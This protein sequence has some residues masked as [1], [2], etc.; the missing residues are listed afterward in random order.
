MNFI[1]VDMINLVACNLNIY[2]GMERKISRACCQVH[3]HSECGVVMISMVTPLHLTVSSSPLCLEDIFLDFA[4]GQGLGVFCLIISRQELCT[5]S[6][7][8]RNR[9]E[10]AVRRRICLKMWF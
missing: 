3:C 6:S 4:K 10:W 2:V 1:F 5:D 7:S 8:V 9:T